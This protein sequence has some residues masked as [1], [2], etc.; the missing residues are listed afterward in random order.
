M[1]QITKNFTHAELQCPMTKK[2]KLAP[3]FA[4]KLQELRDALGRPMHVTSCCRSGEY[5]Q[6]LMDRGFS[7]SVSSFHLM[8]NLVHNTGG[9]CAIDIRAGDGEY[10]AQLSRIALQLGW[11][12][13]VARTFFHLDRRSDYTTREQI[14]FVYK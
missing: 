6:D 10:N 9:T 11:S 2:V 7:A 1:V 14:L 12:V 8:E 13:G 5:N 4:D 3:G